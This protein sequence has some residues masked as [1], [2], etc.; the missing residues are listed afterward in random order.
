[1][2]SKLPGWMFMNIW[3]YNEPCGEKEVLGV[4]DG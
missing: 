1:M 2:I 4:E 3:T